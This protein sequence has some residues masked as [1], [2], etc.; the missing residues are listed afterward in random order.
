[1]LLLYYDIIIANH[2]EYFMY[3]N[4]ACEFTGQDGEQ[5]KNGNILQIYWRDKFN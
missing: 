2:N 5:Y 3:G 4:Y 1:M